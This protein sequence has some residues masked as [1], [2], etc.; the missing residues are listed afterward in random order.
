MSL[1]LFAIPG[2]VAVAI[3]LPVVFSLFVCLLLVAETID[4]F[5][6]FLIV[7]V[8][9]DSSHSVLLLVPKTS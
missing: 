2:V 4:L 8:V 3:L 6:S 5:A 7:G 1:V 9:V